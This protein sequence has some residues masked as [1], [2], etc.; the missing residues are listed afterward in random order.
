MGLNTYKHKKASKLSKLIAKL[1]K[2]NEEDEKI[3]ERREQRKEFKKELALIIAK[4]VRKIIPE[5]DDSTLYVMQIFRFMNKKIEQF[6][7]NLNA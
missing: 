7:Q 1:K 3:E 4:E 5:N 2:K 6:D